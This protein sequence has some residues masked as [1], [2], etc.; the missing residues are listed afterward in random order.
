[1]GEI[2]RGGFVVGRP[3]GPF[4]KPHHV[5]ICLCFITSKVKFSLS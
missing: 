2:A 1:M 4:G 5:L 3:I